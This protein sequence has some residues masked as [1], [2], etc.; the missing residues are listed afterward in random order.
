MSEGKFTFAPCEESSVSGVDGNTNTKDTVN[1]G[2]VHVNLD[3]D[4]GKTWYDLSDVSFLDAFAKALPASDPYVDFS[5]FDTDSNGTI[6]PREL[7][8]LF[9]KAKKGKTYYVKMRYARNKNGKLTWSG[10]ARSLIIFISSIF[11]E[12]SIFSYMLVI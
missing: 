3:M 4:H 8:V 2:I 11:D 6:A 10:Y 5:Q 7:S 9:K 12:T 1:D